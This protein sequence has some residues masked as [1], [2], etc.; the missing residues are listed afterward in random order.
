MDAESSVKAMGAIRIAIGLI[1]WLAPNLAGRLFGLDVDRNQQAP[2]LARLFG[3]RD[4]VLGVATITTSGEDR[5]RWLMAGLVCDTA[6]AAAAG[7]GYRDG[8]L[9]AVTTAMLTAPALLG[10]G[11]GAKALGDDAP[12]TA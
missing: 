4:L 8:Y 11:L 6:D 10:V 2:Y 7:L 1:S 3:V 12:P 5:K 9:P